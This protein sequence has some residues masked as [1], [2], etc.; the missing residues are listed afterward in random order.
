MESLRREIVQYLKEV[1]ACRLCRNVALLV[2][3]SILLIEGAI[4][5]PSY[6]NYERDLLVR[7]AQVGGAVV[8]AGLRN[9]HHDGADD[10]IAAGRLMLMAPE[11]AGGAIY[12]PDGR[13][14][15]TFGEAPA[16]KPSSAQKQSR[17]QDGDPNLAGV[18]HR[19]RQPRGRFR[20]G[21]KN[22]WGSLPRPSADRGAKRR[23]T[24]NVKE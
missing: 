4:L 21:G 6:R 22:D 18:F 3:S 24:L 2:L 14:I 17:W 10:I 13:L 8:G 20:R 16:L 5:V 12:A 19:S 1:L 23:V 7:L 11:I 15:G 9:D